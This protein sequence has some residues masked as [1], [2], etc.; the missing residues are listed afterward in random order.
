[1]STVSQYFV[2]AEHH[3]DQDRIFVYHNQK[4]L[5]NGGELSWCS[6]DLCD[7]LPYA[8]HPLLIEQVGN[9]RYLAVHVEKEIISAVDAQLVPLRN[10]L[11]ESDIDSFRYPGLGNQLLNWY[12]SHR[13]CGT[14]GTATIP[15][16]KERAMVSQYR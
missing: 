10:L 11:I 2:A 1:M 5:V 12:A 3:G 7:L 13:F 8:H 16:E 4:L 14:C 6:E 15:H 9:V